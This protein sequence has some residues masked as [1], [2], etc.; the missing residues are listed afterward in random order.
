MVL[1][2]TSRIRET[3][4]IR[5]FPNCVAGKECQD[6]PAW[7]RIRVHY[8]G[9]LTDLNLVVTREAP[10]EKLVY[11]PR[12]G[13]DFL[14]ELH[15][16]I[17]V[18]VKG[19]IFEAFETSLFL[20]FL[21]NATSETHTLVLSVVCCYLNIF[22]WIIYIKEILSLFRTPSQQILLIVLKFSILRLRLQ[23]DTEGKGSFHTLCPLFLFCL[24]IYNL[25]F[26]EVDS[27]DS[28]KESCWPNKLW[29]QAGKQI[30]RQSIDE[31]ICTLD[32]PDSN[33]YC[34]SH[35]NNI[36]TTMFEPNLK[37]N[38]LNTGKYW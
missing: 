17:L 10:R 15:L 1:L 38:L 36:S 2:S 35:K 29:W 30:V 20:E 25:L 5:R 26:E 37:Q 24:S 28:I 31:K 23:Q 12:T 7:I 6:K 11:N 19:R 22:I 8:E 9:V 3:W 33:M 27:L 18:I 13:V 21:M 16:R 32:N 34:L 4:A 14:R